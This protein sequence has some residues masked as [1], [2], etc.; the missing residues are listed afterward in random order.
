MGGVAFAVV[1]TGSANNPNKPPRGRPVISV[2]QSTSSTSANVIF[3]F[4]NVAPCNGGSLVNPGVG[5][6]SYTARANTGQTGTILAT[7]GGNKIDVNGLAANTVYKFQVFANNEFGSSNTVSCSAAITMQTIAEAPVIGAITTT[8]TTACMP[9]TMP[10]FTGGNTITSSTVSISGPGATFTNP[11]SAPFTAPFSGLS[12]SV[13]YTFTA[14]VTTPIGTGRSSTRCGT[15]KGPVTINYMVIAGGG[16]GGASRLSQLTSGPF[17]LGTPQS[18]GGG[19][20]GGGGVTQGSFVKAPGSVLSFTVGTG[21]AGGPAAIGAGSQ[22]NPSSLTCATTALGGGYGNGLAY[23]PTAFNGAVGGGN[24]GPGGN[25]GGASV[26]LKGNPVTPTCNGWVPTSGGAGSQGFPGGGAQGGAGGPPFPSFPQ[27]GG[28]GGGG[29]AGGA[30]GT[31]LAGPQSNPPFGSRPGEGGVGGAGTTW[32]FTGTG[33]FPAG[34]ITRT[35]GSG[36]GAAGMFPSCISL[37][38]TPGGG[39][40]I[41]TGG[42]GG[43]PVNASTV[44]A[45][46]NTGGVFIAVL[47]TQYPG[48]APGATVTNP[49]SAPGYTVLQY[50][51]PG[52]YTV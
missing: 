34:V 39:T 40:G 36:G 41:G 37:A 25:G 29:G 4:P 20:G 48:T 52:T 1:H 12:P 22:G 17:P 38:R 14:S 31:G 24:G 43:A 46:G 7:S 44:G 10:T 27:G 45:T 19:G 26:R 28:G 16:G 13:T 35:Y 33:P 49:P 9:I 2:V 8:C 23:G 5:I 21:G 3:T 30:G 6:I 51:A 47:T 11:G 32:P 15:T 18:A 42:R 50:T